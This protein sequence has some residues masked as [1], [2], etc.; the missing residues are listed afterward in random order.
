MIIW[1]TGLPS[2]GKTTLAKAV[3]ERL[4]QIR[5]EI[6]DADEIRPRFWPELLFSEEDRNANVTRLAHLARMLE[7]HGVTVLVAA[8]SP[9]Q[10]TR[11]IARKLAREFIEVYVKCPVEV[12]I[13]RDVKGYYKQALAGEMKGFTGVDDPYQAPQRPEIIVESSVLNLPACVDQ[14]M[15]CLRE[16]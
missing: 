2:S 15:R 3:R 9:Y 11:L 5:V 16:R 12:C 1:F 13:Q 7:N 10:L 6:L 4:N 14:V 8:V